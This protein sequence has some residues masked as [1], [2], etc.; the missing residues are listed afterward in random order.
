ML[1]YICLG[2]RSFFNFGIRFPRVRAYF[3]NEFRQA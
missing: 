3:V 2:A 1:W